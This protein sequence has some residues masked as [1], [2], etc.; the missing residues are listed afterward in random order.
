[1]TAKSDR[2]LEQQKAAAYGKAVEHASLEVVR[3]VSSSFDVDPRFHDEGLEIERF[4]TQNVRGFEFIETSRSLLG[5]VQCKFWVQR[6]SEKTDDSAE[7]SKELAKEE[8][9]ASIDARYL[10]LFKVSGEHTAE[11]LKVFFNQIAPISVWPY[12]RVHVASLSAEADLDIPPLPLKK[13]V[14]KVKAAGNYVN[15]EDKPS[16]P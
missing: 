12:F 2:K 14:H 16:Q 9:L 8:K 3:L 15:P 10:V 5:M 7:D 13:L 4:V 6:A 1:M 11:S